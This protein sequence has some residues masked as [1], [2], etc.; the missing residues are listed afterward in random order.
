MTFSG[1]NNGDD[2][3]VAALYLD[4]E[5]KG[6]LR[7]RRQTFT[8][9][10]PRTVLFLGLSYIGLMDDLACFRRALGKTEIK[11]LMELPGGVGTL[12]PKREHGERSS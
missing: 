12:A 1:F 6:E 5:L 9:E 2:K 11:A 7:R 8:W 10:L 3:G 4:G